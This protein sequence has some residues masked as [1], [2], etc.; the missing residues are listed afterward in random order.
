[1]NYISKI[2]S[3]ITASLICSSSSYATLIGDSVGL[4]FGF[5]GGAALFT[6]TAIVSDPGI[7]FNVPLAPQFV[8]SPVVPVDVKGSSFD[9]I[10]DLTGFQSLGNL[11]TFELFDLDWPGGTIT[12]VELIS[13]NPDDV[14]NISFT[15]D[16]IWVDFNDL[17]NPPAINAFSFAIV[18]EPAT[19]PLLLGM[20]AIGLVIGVKKFK[21]N[22]S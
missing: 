14:A 13:G 9:I 22:L 5:T 17:D 8:N 11:T 1:M 15:D 10:F 2:L 16:S 3:L 4:R 19:T 12:H 6:N 20:A 7:E 21:N 18:T